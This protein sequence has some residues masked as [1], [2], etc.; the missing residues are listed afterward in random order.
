MSW[1][2]RLH[3]LDRI[4]ENVGVT[5]SEVCL[6]EERAYFF[7]L[8]LPLTRFEPTPLLVEI[9]VGGRDSTCVWT[10]QRADHY[11]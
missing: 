11:T 2:Q 5:E 7:P 6:P 1:G 4:W 3:M 8:D 10:G 9:P